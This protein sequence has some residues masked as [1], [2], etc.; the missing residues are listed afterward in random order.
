[1]PT[2]SKAVNGL[3]KMIK[4]ISKTLTRTRI[5][6]ITKKVFRLKKFL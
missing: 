4:K 6:K 3:N 5:D 2:D 1:M